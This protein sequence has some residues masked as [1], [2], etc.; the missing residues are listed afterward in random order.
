MMPAA[1]A[2]ITA[3]DELA[4]ATAHEMA[5]EAGRAAEKAAAIRRIIDGGPNGLTQKPH[6]ASSAEAI[7]ETDEQYAAYL[8]QQ[9]DAVIAKI[10]AQARYDSAVLIALGLVP[11]RT[12][13]VEV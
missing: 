3:G 8:A 10:Q 5:L 2:I 11:P 9:R 4:R 6:S 12:T 1:Q 7:V 13:L